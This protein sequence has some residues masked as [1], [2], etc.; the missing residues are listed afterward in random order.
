MGAVPWDTLPDEIWTIILSK[1]SIQTLIQAQNVNSRFESLVQ[2]W[3]L[4]TSKKHSTFNRKSIFLRRK[5]IKKALVWGFSHTTHFSIF[6]VKMIKNQ[7][8]IV[9]QLKNEFITLL[10]R[11]KLCEIVWKSYICNAI[12]LILISSFKPKPSRSPFSKIFYTKKTQ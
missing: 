1:S 2:P 3:V 6:T 8:K 9:Q 7:R 5:L 10:I 4:K 12:E 11:P